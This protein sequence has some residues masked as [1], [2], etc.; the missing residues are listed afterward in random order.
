M[1][2]R[3]VT[4]RVFSERVCKILCKEEREGRALVGGIKGRQIG[5]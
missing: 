4:L 1:L 2:R 5:G 3:K